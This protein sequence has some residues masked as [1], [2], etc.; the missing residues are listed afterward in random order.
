MAEVSRGLGRERLA[1]VG[2]FE[3]PGG[4]VVVVD[5]GHDA[6]GEVIDRGE[7]GAPEE[8]AG[9]DGEPDLDLIEPGAVGGRV[10][11]D[12]AMGGIG[13]EGGAGLAGEGPSPAG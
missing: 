9:Q 11:E 7:G 5:E 10:V 4:A 2:P 8:L 1:L 13:Q 12:D 3:G 6:G